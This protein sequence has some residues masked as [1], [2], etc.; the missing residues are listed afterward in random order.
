MWPHARG[1]YANHLGVT[2][3]ADRVR[4]AYGDEK[5]A[6]LVARKDRCDPTNLSRFNQIIPPSVQAGWRD[7][8]AT[9]QHVYRC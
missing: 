2:E 1:V 6:R 9:D 5:F 8:E 7:V 4:A 3:G